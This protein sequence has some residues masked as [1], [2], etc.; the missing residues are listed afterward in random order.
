MLTIEGR[1]PTNCKVNGFC[2]GH[3]RREFLKIGALGAGGMTLADLLRAE[4]EAKIGRSQKAIINIFLPG[5]P[6]HLDM[7]DLK[8]E[9][10][11]EIRG[12]FMPIPTN[13]PGI[14]ICELFPRL[15]TLMDKCIIIRSIAD[16]QSGHVACQCMTGRKLST[17]TERFHPS[18]GAWVSRL[19]N[20]ANPGIP[21][22]LS[23]M[24]KT[25]HK[26]WGDP[27]H[28]G[29]LGMAHAAF[30]LKGGKDE[31]SASDT[32]KDRK[33]NGITLERLRDRKLLMQAM[34]RF[35]RDADTAG[36]MTGIDSCT[37]QALGILTS[38]S[39]T[40]ALDLSQ[41]DSKIV[42]RYGQG[43]PEFRADGAPKLT[44]NFLLARRLVE[45]GARYVSLNFSR[46]DWHS[47]NFNRAR[48]DFPMLDNALS[49]LI[50][51][52]KERQMLDDVSV[53]CWGE[54]GRTP[55]INSKKGRDHWS[56]VS[57]ALMA[58][59]G[60][61]TGQVIGSTNRLAEVPKDR[62]VKFQEIFATLYHNMGLF[63]MPER[64]FDF[65]GRSQSPID[66]GV[67]PLREL[68]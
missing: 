18:A 66:E 2:D 5:G 52:L 59:G 15:A 26:Q 10:P 20:S 67:Q 33:L 29:F 28:G 35:K 56:R 27:G 4:A 7:W 31:N 54:F 9:A 21:S 43:D 55:K 61:Q 14:E 46:W 65:R 62:P 3:S 60:M 32:V 37:E 39:L 16:C 17:N 41:E 23:L 22:H 19:L 44:E 42:A 13:V 24:H 38:S 25:S 63:P 45:A 34:D 40:Q 51:D 53:I 1:R 6:P 12:E 57:A 36:Q 11:S 8:P 30:R 47:D 58:G 48:T 64:V 68:V 50:L 49:A